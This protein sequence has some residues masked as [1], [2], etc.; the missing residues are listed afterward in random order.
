MRSEELELILPKLSYMEMC[1]KKYYLNDQ[2]FIKRVGYSI[3]PDLQIMS[4]DFVQHMTSI[5]GPDNCS[6]LGT[7]NFEKD[8]FKVPL[9]NNSSS[10]EIHEITPGTNGQNEKKPG[11][12]ESHDEKTITTNEIYE[13]TLNSN[14]LISETADI[15]I[16]RI[17]RY[18]DLTEIFDS[19]SILYVLSGELNFKIS[20][21]DYTLKKGNIVIVPPYVMVNVFLNND[22]TVVLALIIRTSSFIKNFQGIIESGNSCSDFFVKLL[23]DKENTPFSIINSPFDEYLKDILFRILLL[24]YEAS[25]FQN[26]LIRN[27]TEDFLLHMFS[28]Y[29]ECMVIYDNNV[30]TNELVS[31][32]LVYLHKNY[33]N[34]TLSDVSRE[35]SYSSAHISRVL[36]QGL[37]KKYQELITE[38]R[39][40]KAQELLTN[41]YLG[42]EDICQILGYSNPRHLRFLFSKA[43]N[44]SPSQFRKKCSRK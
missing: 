18:L 37:G 3:D 6:F 17:P 36:Y 7:G 13:H 44:I 40:T 15:A 9:Y 26:L 11:S 12:N 24:Q 29:K 1:Y 34:V 28:R 30:K 33:S 22:N 25:E 5:Y 4:N 2:P 21:R 32:I 14:A 39:L 20:G 27:L 23:Y 38:I 16:M 8:S 31:R 42:I 41:T 43:F 19:I 35:F 10:D